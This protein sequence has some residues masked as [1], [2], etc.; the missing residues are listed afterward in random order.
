MRHNAADVR[1]LRYAVRVLP[2]MLADQLI[3][4]FSIA[5]ARHLELEIAC[6]QLEQMLEQLFIRHI[7]AVDGI[8][9]AAWANMD[10]DL[11]SFFRRETIEDPIVEF[12]K[13][14]ISF[15]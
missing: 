11:L 6:I 8:N 12:K 9:I 4:G 7:R 5:F 1:H 10:A 2:E 15:G 13:R 3:S 14:A